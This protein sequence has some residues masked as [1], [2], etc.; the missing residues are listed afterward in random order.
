MDDGNEW[1]PTDTQILEL[2]DTAEQQE[3]EKNGS[4]LE[5]NNGGCAS[6]SNRNRPSDSAM[7]ANRRTDCM[8]HTRGDSGYRNRPAGGGRPQHPLGAI[9]PEVSAT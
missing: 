8:G 4:K 9:G 1:N 3:R 5:N 7:A 2:W 6:H